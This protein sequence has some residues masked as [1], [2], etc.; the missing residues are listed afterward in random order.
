MN[1][2]VISDSDTSITYTTDHTRVTKS[3]E[4]VFETFIKKG[5]MFQR[6]RFYQI[7]K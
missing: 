7:H 4:M 2:A 5:M 1:D 6:R 3:I